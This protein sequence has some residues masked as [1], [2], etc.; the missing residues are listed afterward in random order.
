MKMKIASFITIFVLNLMLKVF[1][2]TG[3]LC[4]FKLYLPDTLNKYNIKTFPL[5]LQYDDSIPTIDTTY[6]I[7]NLISIR[8]G[9]IYEGQIGRRARMCISHLKDTMVIDFS[10]FP[11]SPY[12]IDTISFIPAYFVYIVPLAPSS[13]GEKERDSLKTKPWLIAGRIKGITKD[14]NVNTVWLKEYKLK[15]Y[16]KLVT[17]CT[18]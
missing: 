14:M 10:G 12:Y 9:C 13:F 11:D 15:T 5:N 6:K 2:Q 17:P 8:N 16:R 18:K 7:G 3:Y 1:A 4:H